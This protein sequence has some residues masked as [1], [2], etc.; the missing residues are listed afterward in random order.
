[1]LPD[2]SRVD[3]VL[4]LLGVVESCGDGIPIED[5]PLQG[6]DGLQNGLAQLNVKGEEKENLLAKPITDW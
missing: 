1:M 2:T 4:K 6:V 5:P 3:S